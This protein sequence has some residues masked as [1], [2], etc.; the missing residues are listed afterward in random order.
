[1]STSLELPIEYIFPKNPLTGAVPS[2]SWNTL[3]RAVPSIISWQVLLSH[4]FLD[5]CC[6]LICFLKTSWC[7][8]HRQLFPGNIL[9]GAEISIV[10]WNI[11]MG[12]VPSIVSWKHPDECCTLNCSLKTSWWFL[13]RQ[14]FP[15]NILMGA[16]PPLFPENI[17]TGAVLIRTLPSI[18]FS[19][20]NIRPGCKSYIEQFHLM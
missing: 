20:H 11:L 17:L 7:V 4:L 1:M 15:E 8:L 12:A 6:T 13:H 19:L 3:M 10:S 9:M 16:V 5:G 2:V 14:L 18:L